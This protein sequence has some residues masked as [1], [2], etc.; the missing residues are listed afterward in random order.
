MTKNALSE[1]E[2]YILNKI[3]NIPPHLKATFI[4][5][6]IFSLIVHGFGFFNVFVNED[7]LFGDFYH[8][9]AYLYQ[10]GRWFLVGL[11]YIS[12]FYT[13]PWV[14]GIFITLYLSIAVT[15]IVSILEIK[16]KLHCV[17]ISLLIVTFP[18]WANSFMYSYMADA[19]PAAMLLTVLAVFVTKKH[20]FGYIAGGIFIML[21][22][23]LYQSFLGFAIALSLMLLIKHL[24]TEYKGIKPFALYALRFM[25]LGV[26]GI[27]F[28]LVSIR[29]SL[30]ITGGQLWDH[31]GLGDLNDFPFERIP[32]LIANTYAYLAIGFISGNRPD[33]LFVSNGL[34]AL[35]IVLLT[36]I[37]MFLTIAIIKTRIYKNIP[38]II[39]L[40]LCLA[41]LPFGFNIT[42]TIS[43][44]GWMHTLMTTP[45]VLGVIF[46][47]FIISITPETE[48]II[49]TAALRLA[50]LCITVLI[51]GNYVRQTGTL[52]LVQHVQYERTFAFYNRL[53][54]RIEE[55]PGYEPGMPVAIIGTSPFPYIGMAYS[56]HSE[57]WRTVGFNAQRP[58]VGLGEPNKVARF[59]YSFLGVRIELANT[60]QT[61][62]VLS[63]NEFEAMP[64]YPRH[65]S[66]RVI[67]DVLVVR[68]N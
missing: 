41:L 55:T 30:L 59:M 4:A 7:V 23:A 66:V 46:V 8:S 37:A 54:V 44:D 60:E 45:F 9:L 51:G 61:A 42:S 64:L 38:A 26:L 62:A 18:A 57:T 65:G 40:V 63:S 34:F 5:S 1:P 49:N 28:Y 39:I 33:W 22:L 6:I 53:L 27:V 48:A 52:Y 29:I 15:L 58:A 3:K 24:L 20:R 16:N 50:A 13:I 32:Q 12:G 47:F 67:D 35:Y 19:Y 2:N 43:P 21:A 10:S 31:Q 25:L 14:I 11:Q 56:L 68:L 17:I 36:L